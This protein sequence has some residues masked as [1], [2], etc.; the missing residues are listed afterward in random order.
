[1]K[2]SIKEFHF[3]KYAAALLFVLAITNAFTAYSQTPA[4][5][6]EK[7]TTVQAKADDLA[8]A[9]ETA[10]K[11]ETEKAK[12]AAENVNRLPVITEQTI[13][14]ISIM[15]FVVMLVLIILFFIQAYKKNMYLGFQSIKFIGLVIMF[16]GICIIALTGGGLISDS[17]LA[18]L[19]GTIAGYVLSKEDDVPNAAKDALKKEN[20]TLKA[21]VKE[22]EELLAP[23]I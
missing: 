3:I 19:L 6:N 22:L 17:T 23:K 4:S 1:M 14:T 5:N 18:A 7:E 10:K 21:K 9:A 2:K 8:K 20:E 11:E 13:K 16:P 12:T 15:F